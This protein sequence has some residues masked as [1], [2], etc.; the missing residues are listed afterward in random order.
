VRISK[1]FI[2]IA[3]TCAFTSVRAQFSEPIIHSD[4]GLEN[5]HN[6]HFL[7][8]NSD[9]EQDLIA[10]TSNSVYLIKDSND[11]ELL[12]SLADG[13][14]FETSTTHD[15]DS[16]G[17][18]DIAIF[19]RNGG[20]DIR[21]FLYENQDG[22]FELKDDL[23]L[24]IQS[25]FP[26]PLKLY[27][28]DLFNDGQ[29]SIVYGDGMEVGRIAYLNSSYVAINLKTI[30]EQNFSASTPASLFE[31]IDF[32][33]DGNMDL[34]WFHQRFF[35]FRV[36]VS[37]SDGNTFLGET[38]LQFDSEVSTFIAAT[39]E[40]NGPHFTID[41]DNDGDSDLLVSS[42]ITQTINW[43]ENIDGEQLSAPKLL[44]TNFSTDDE[45]SFK[46]NNL[47]KYDV[48]GDGLFDYLLSNENEIS[49]NRNRGDET[50]QEIPLFDYQADA[51]TI[52]N[53][54]NDNRPDLALST[55]P[56]ALIAY[57]Q[58]DVPN[59]AFEATKDDPCGAD[60]VFLNQSICHYPNTSFLWDFGNGI[61]SNEFNPNIIYDGSGLY[62]VSLE[63]CNDFGCDTHTEEIVVLVPDVFIPD[64]IDLAQTYLFEDNSLFIE[65][66]TWSFGDGE[67]STW[68]FVE[69]TY[70]FPGIYLVE[71][72]LNTSNPAVCQFV[73]KKEVVVPPIL[74]DDD[75]LI[76]FPNPMTDRCEVIFEN[77]KNKPYRIQIFNNLGQE[78]FDNQ[79]S[80]GFYYAFNNELLIEGVYFIHLTLNGVFVDTKKII[81]VEP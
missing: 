61:T 21:A 54:D 57:D 17:D 2:L 33:S 10:V 23:L 39:P 79:T 27:T 78:I 38:E 72:F 52:G 22:G 44:A 28:V 76:I 42:Y 77:K 14:F 34:M 53:L 7:D 40:F 65:N 69:H 60:K 47:I 8:Y 58:E 46:P 45:F 70:N 12:F 36:F 67:V 13:W 43:I 48:D 26:L 11:N 16:D 5:I 3:F 19:G 1:A 37:L 25:N 81:V 32:N 75:G 15:L 29:Q 18:L 51:L 71:L 49:W 55:G 66:R 59:T 24:G 80:E 41:I 6:I 68:Q 50:F 35:N 30:S 63:A 31:L 56:N 4:W 74:E 73:I 9:G 20:A 62:E 64:T